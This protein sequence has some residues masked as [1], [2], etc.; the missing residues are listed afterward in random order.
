MKKNT[1]SFPK[2]GLDK[3]T[4]LQKMTERRA[5]DTHWQTGKAFALVYHPGKER[6]EAIKAAYD[7]FFSEN[8]LNPTAFPSLRQFEAE[9]IAMT[10][11]LFHGDENTCGSL[12]SGGTESILLA[13]KTAREWGKKKMKIAHPEIL[14][15]ETAHPAFYKAGYYFGVKVTKIPVRED[16]R[17]DMEAMKAAVS[18]NTV[19]LVGSAP[20]YPHGVID[21]ISELSD[22]A[23]EK[24]L[25]LHVDACIGGFM[26]PF[27][28]KLGWPIPDWDFSL[29][30]VTSISADVHK[31][32]YAAK[33]ASTI[34]YRNHELRKHQFYVIT[35]WSGGI[36]GSPTMLGT[37]PGGAI[38]AAW[39]ALMTI[40]E[41]G[42]LEMAA[43]TLKATQML[44]EGIAAHPELKIIGQP[45][46]SLFAF[47][48]SEEGKNIDIYALA[49]ELSKMG[50]SFDRN[51][52]PISIHIT[53]NQIHLEV[54]SDFL[55]DLKTALDKVKKFRLSHVTS[56]VQIKA[57]KGLQKILPEGALAKIQ[58]AT[59]G[60]GGGGAPKAAMYG[61]MGALAGTGDL[62]T[63]VLNFLDKLNG[64]EKVE[65]KASES[66]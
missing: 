41:A 65:I 51:A 35:D 2:A 27:A 62:H 19:L 5:N 25:L 20:S 64:L 26:T 45:D 55:A 50:W 56:K 60:K 31:Y 53:V 46:V 59:A 36:Y 37:R 61:M 39:A 66:D 4:L 47:G 30:G 29:P 24:G 23:V 13:V 11:D 58:S 54:V 16:F 38:A 48:N 34:L 10:A 12:S 63:M 21:P 40:G 33:G 44:Q 32:G 8:A 43:R 6:S 15:P 9:V 52:V 18:E 49:D 14:I 22:L 7:M 3:E 57:V 1:I 28:K 42:Y 17:V